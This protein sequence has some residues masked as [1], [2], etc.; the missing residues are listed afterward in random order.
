ML[1]KY[2][3]FPGSREPPF[4]FSSS[5]FFNYYFQACSIH[6]PFLCFLFS[7]VV[8]ENNK[9]ECLLTIFETHTYTHTDLPCMYSLP[10]LEGLL[11]L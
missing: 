10:E 7:S 9:K 1:T 3:A 4:K 11:I 2:P 5:M 8:S 6:L